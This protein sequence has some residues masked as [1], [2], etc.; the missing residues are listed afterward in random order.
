MYSS[1]FLSFLEHDYNYLVMTAQILDADGSVLWEYPNFQ[2]RLRPLTPLLNLQFADFDEAAAN[3]TE[4]V[5]V[6]F[7]TIPG[8]SRA[9]AKPASSLVKERRGSQLYATVFDEMVAMLKP[10]FRWP[11]EEEQAG[12]AAAGTTQG[13]AGKCSTRKGRAAQR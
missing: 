3:V 13:G 8:I 5:D 12:A 11:W 4:Q 6:K 9:F 7:K 2:E 1:N 10:T